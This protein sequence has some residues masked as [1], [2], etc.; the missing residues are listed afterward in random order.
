M[1]HFI[2]TRITREAVQ[3]TRMSRAPLT[4]ILAT[5]TLATV[6]VA[7][8]RV[9][10]KVGTGKRGNGEMRNFPDDL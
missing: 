4:C 8:G 6:A 5:P 1:G 9:V 3:V 2:D 10:L 7:A